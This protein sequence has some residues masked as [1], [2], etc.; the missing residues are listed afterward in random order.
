LSNRFGTTIQID[1]LYPQAFALKTW[2][3]EI[4]PLL[5]TYT[6]KNTTATGSLLFVPFEEHIVPI[7]NTQQQSLGQIFHVQAQLSISNETQRFCVLVCSD[8][9]QIFPRNWSQRR[10]YCT[11]CR[12]SIHLTPR[13]QENI[14]T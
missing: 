14:F 13:Y 8:C 2:S 11:T 5:S 6:T 9:K 4:K 10:F 7:V 3:D 12:R 1:P